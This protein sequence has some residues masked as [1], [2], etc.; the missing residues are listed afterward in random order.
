MGEMPRFDGGKSYQVRRGVER[1]QPVK[2]LDVPFLAQRRVE[3]A[4]HMNFRDACRE[5][6][7]D[8]GDNLVNRALERM[9]VALFRGEGAKLAR[10]DT[11]V[12]IVD[13]AIKDIG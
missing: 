5:R 3:T 7:L 13:V 8:R 11:D 9:R 6:F 2:Q 10:E 4:D 12:R 1:A